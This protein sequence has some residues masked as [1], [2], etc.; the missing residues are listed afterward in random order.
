MMLAEPGGVKLT[1]QR[2]AQTVRP[3]FWIEIHWL[4]LTALVGQNAV[5]SLIRFAE[6]DR[7]AS[8]NRRGLCRSLPR[9]W[10]GLC[11]R[12]RWRSG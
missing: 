4:V 8:R 7:P 2:Y 5:I 10:Q 9:F 1:R 3:E 11:Y 12:N 6:D